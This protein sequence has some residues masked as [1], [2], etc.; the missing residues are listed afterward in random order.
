MCYHVIWAMEASIR[1]RQ[2]ALLWKTIRSKQLLV[3]EQLR[4][5]WGTSWE[6]R[7]GTSRGT[8]VSNDGERSSFHLVVATIGVHHESGYCSTLI[9]PAY[10][11][12]HVDISCY[13]KEGFLKLEEE[14]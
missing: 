1:M 13:I 10:C 4:D 6:T 3:E 5:H 14:V 12:S 7:R 9:S 8:A 11:L 2:R